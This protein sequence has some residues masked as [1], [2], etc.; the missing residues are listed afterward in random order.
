MAGTLDGFELSRIDLEQRKE[1]DVL[2]ASQSGR[3]SS[4]KLLRVLHDEDLLRDAR[5]AAT[6]LI[7]RDPE[8]TT[9]PAL[10][11][12]VAALVTS[13]QATFLEKS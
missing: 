10:A 4:L 2:G 8:L 11:A 1:G 3:R 7:E 12:A 6:A 5:D 9:E 13:D